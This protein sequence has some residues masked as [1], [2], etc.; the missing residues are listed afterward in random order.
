MDSVL[1][2]TGV[3]YAIFDARD[4][5]SAEGARKAELIEMLQVVVPWPTMYETLRTRFVKNKP[6]LGR[7][8]RFLKGRQVVYLDD[9]GYRDEAFELSFEWSLRRKR[10][11]SM[12]DWI[13]RLVIDDVNVRLA[14]LATFNANDF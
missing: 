1:V 5:R 3:W 10:P 4:E 12:V 6:A 2:D 13:I 9:A 11:I 14:Y 7:F 8:E